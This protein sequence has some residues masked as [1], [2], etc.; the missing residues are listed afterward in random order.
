MFDPLIH[1]FFQLISGLL[2]KVHFYEVEYFH[3]FLLSCYLS[4]FPLQFVQKLTIE[5]YRVDKDQKLLVLNIIPLLL[6]IKESL[7]IGDF[8]ILENLEEIGSEVDVLKRGD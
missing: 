3:I 2:I 1:Q 4:H 5:L 7:N 6:V 8:N